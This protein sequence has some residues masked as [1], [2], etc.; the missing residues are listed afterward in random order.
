MKRFALLFLILILLLSM[1]LPTYAAGTAFS[2]QDEIRHESAVAVLTDLGLISGFSDGSFQPAEPIKREQI[3]KL[4]ALL[5]TDEIPQTQ[6]VDFADVETTSWAIPYIAYCEQRGI[7]VG[8][9][10]LFRPKDNVT[11]QELAKMLLVVLGFDAERYTGREWAA[12]VMS[13]AEKC[14]L[15]HGLSGSNTREICRDDA[16]RMILNALQSS[17]IVGF[18]GEDAIFALDDLMNVQTF[19]EYRYGVQRY[20]GMLAANEEGSL[21]GKGK[22]EE[23]QTKLLG[24]KTFEVS[25]DASLLGQMVAVYLKDGE[26]IGLPCVVP[27]QTSE[28]FEQLADLQKLMDIAG[29]SISE[30]ALFFLNAKKTT[31]QVLEKLP[32]AYTVTVYDHDGDLCYDVVMVKT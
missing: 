16:C 14:R 30:D 1:A 4:I 2:D 28:C 9:N 8:S 13:D 20:S 32:S 10:G 11:A 5:C 17:A 22:L 7:I 25:S 18:D 3:A 15:Y 23:G 21:I 27:E 12:N 29:F 19:M 31:A 24:L 6:Y 26:V